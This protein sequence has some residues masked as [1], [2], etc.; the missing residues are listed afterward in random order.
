MPAQNQIEARSLAI[1]SNYKLLYKYKSFNL[2]QFYGLRFSKTSKQSYP[3]NKNSVSKVKKVDI[4][5]KKK[6][7]FI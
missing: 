7:K 5:K 6:K 1:K 3:E 4:K 2:K